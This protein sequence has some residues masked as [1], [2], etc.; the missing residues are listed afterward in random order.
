MSHDRL[1]PLALNQITTK[2]R[3][4]LLILVGL[5]SRFNAVVL[6]IT[7]DIRYLEIQCTNL[8]NKDR[9]K[10]TM[11][12]DWIKINE[13]RYKVQV[14]GGSYEREKVKYI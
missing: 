7:T 6:S 14:D 9:E 10:Q 13:N 11:I 1:R 3:W 2:H 12:S 4:L 5:I 8:E